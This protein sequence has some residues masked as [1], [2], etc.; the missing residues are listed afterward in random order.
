[1]LPFFDLAMQRLPAGRQDCQFSMFEVSSSPA[2][3][4]RAS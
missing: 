4:Y 3:Y 1:M 2:N